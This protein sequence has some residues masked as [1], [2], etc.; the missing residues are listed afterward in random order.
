MGGLIGAALA[1]ANYFHAI[2]IYEGGDDIR[3][4]KT[5]GLFAVYPVLLIVEKG[6]NTE[7]TYESARLYDKRICILFRVPRDG[8][9]CDR[10]FLYV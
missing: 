9:P 7:L 2:N 10:C 3:T 1:Y 4:L 8:G 6:I 5:A